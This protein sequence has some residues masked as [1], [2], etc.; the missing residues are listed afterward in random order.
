M[1]TTYNRK[2]NCSPSKVPLIIEPSQENILHWF[3]KSVECLN[4]E[5]QDF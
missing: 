5:R 2:V 1:K 4:T 3:S